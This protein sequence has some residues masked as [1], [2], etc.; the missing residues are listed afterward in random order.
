MRGQAVAGTHGE[1]TVG[2][3][4]AAAVSRGGCCVTFGGQRR[5]RLN[6]VHPLPPSTPSPPCSIQSVRSA[7]IM[8]PKLRLHL[9]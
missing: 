5:V 1:L 7:S 3:G 6:D 2:Y 8:V 4:S 9:Q